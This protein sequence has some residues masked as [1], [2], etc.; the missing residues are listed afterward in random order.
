MTFKRIS[1][2]LHFYHHFLGVLPTYLTLFQ[3]IAPYVNRFNAWLLLNEKN[4]QEQEAEIE[5]LYFKVIDF[6]VQTD[7]SKL[8]KERAFLILATT[9]RYSSIISDMLA[10]GAKMELYGDVPLRIAAENGDA[11]IVSILCRA[12]ACLD[13]NNPLFFKHLNVVEIYVAEQKLSIS[14][15]T[16]VLFYAIKDNNFPLVEY[17]IDKIP[18]INATDGLGRTPLI[19]SA[20]LGHQSIVSFL[21]KKGASLDVKDRSNRTALVYAASFNHLGVVNALLM[22]VT[23]Y[24]IASQSL[25]TALSIATMYGYIPVM[26]TLIEAGGD[27][28]CKDP[29]G[30]TL[31]FKTISS[32]DLKR[33]RTLLDLGANPNTQNDFG[34]TPLMQAAW[35]GE[36][37][38]VTALLRS[39]ARL[40]TLNRY[41]STAIFWAIEGG[42][43]EVIRTLILAGADLMLVNITDTKNP[44]SGESP[45][46][47]AILYGHENVAELIRKGLI[48]QAFWDLKD[49]CD[50]SGVRKKIQLFEFHG[51]AKGDVVDYLINSKRDPKEQLELLHEAVAC[52]ANGRPSNALS[53][54]MHTPQG[55]GFRRFFSQ[56]PTYAVSR[57]KSAINL[58]TP[59]QTS[60]KFEDYPISFFK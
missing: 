3:K 14:D 13:L 5:R 45:Y 46:S 20:E 59:H 56:E 1:L 8:L 55:V 39:G 41:E 37:H 4:Q 16:K 43:Y 38:I 23:R 44:I 12:G 60:G 28:N 29:N 51:V 54:Y 7:S 2:L 27:P 10:A 21:I 32:R 47:L 18:N 22:H 30:D 53:L 15:L 57:I 17:L 26:R 50:M 25:V 34:F 48:R 31:L 49:R 19:L 36:I 33:I 9:H 42:H 24:P 6:F 40:N 11:S 52:D 58:L 35:L